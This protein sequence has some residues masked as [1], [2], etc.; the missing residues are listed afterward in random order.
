MDTEIETETE[1]ET[2]SNLKT[3]DKKAYM[4]EY[5]RKRYNENK[6][7]C[8]AYKNSVKC[9]ITHNLPAEELKEY[10]MYLADI[11]RLRK[12]KEKLPTDLFEKIIQETYP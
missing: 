12:I 8:R 5:M 4:R 6:E 10:G 11:Y 9:K 7:K 2:K 3:A 1:T